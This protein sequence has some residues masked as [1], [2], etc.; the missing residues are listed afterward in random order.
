M[1][2]LFVV[3][4]AFTM[5]SAAVDACHASE[6]KIALIIANESYGASIGKPLK[7]PREGA[8]LVAE[9]LSKLGGFDYSRANNATE[10]IVLDADMELLD[11]EVAAYVA[12]IKAAGPDVTSFFYFAGHGASDARGVNYLIPA[13]LNTGSLKRLWDNSYKL[14]SL[15]EALRPLAGHGA[16]FIVIDAC[17]SEFN[18]ASGEGL[19]VVEREDLPQGIFLV[20]STGGGKSAPDD[21]LFAE[22]LSGELIR[23]NVSAYDLFRSVAEAVHERSGKLREPSIVGKLS[24]PVYFGRTGGQLTDGEIIAT[25]NRRVLFVKTT[26]VYRHPSTTSGVVEIRG[27]GSTHVSSTDDEINETR[28]GDQDWITFQT[29]WEMGYVPKQY[30]SLERY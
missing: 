29:N 27:Q 14:T 3:I 5:W 17:R 28:S 30:V 15:I 25:G 21:L 7:Y 22:A 1:K 19:A 8:A 23:R 16:H 13:K 18:L 4:C 9:A 10:H 11:L 6:K 12:R 2:T 24:S 26:K 20:F